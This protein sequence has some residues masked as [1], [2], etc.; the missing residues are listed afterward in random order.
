[1]KKM[2]AF[3][4]ALFLAIACAGCSRPAEEPP[5]D[6]AAAAPAETASD[7]SSAPAPERK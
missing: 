4:L 7:A 2:M 3:L 1:M 6:G 5:A